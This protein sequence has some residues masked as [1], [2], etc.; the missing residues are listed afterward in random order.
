[1]R[2][3]LKAFCEKY[4]FSYRGMQDRAAKGEFPHS[5]GGR[6]GSLV[7]VFDDTLL[8]FFKRQDEENAK[9]KAEA[10]TKA[11]CRPTCMEHRRKKTQVSAENWTEE[12]RRGIAERKAEQAAKQLAGEAV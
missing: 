7:Y 10:I 5:G 11:K 4:G 2:M 3:T 12:L 9:K 1:M 6:K 8:E